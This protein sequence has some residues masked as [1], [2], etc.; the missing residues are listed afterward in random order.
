MWNHNIK[1]INVPYLLYKKVLQKLPQIELSSS[2]KLTFCEWYKVKSF[3][4]KSIRNCDSK[5]HIFFKNHAIASTKRH[6]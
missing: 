1:I 2:Y 3:I 4:H 5:I 6:L